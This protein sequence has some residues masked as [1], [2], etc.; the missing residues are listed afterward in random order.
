MVLRRERIKLR[1]QDIVYSHIVVIQDSASRFTA[2][3]IVQLTRADKVLPVLSDIYS[4][5]KSRKPDNGQFNSRH[6]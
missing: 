6:G 1:H 4:M 2:A 5:R 3:K